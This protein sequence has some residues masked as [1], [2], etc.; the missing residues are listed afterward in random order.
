MS[1]FGSK[2]DLNQGL[3]E[4]PLV[5]DQGGFSRSRQAH[6]DEDLAFFDLKV[7][8]PQAYRCPPLHTAELP[9][10][11]GYRLDIGLRALTGHFTSS[12]KFSPSTAALR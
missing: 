2:A 5:A 7:D 11:V 1:A 3:A 6:D 12:T 10:D 9:T 8:V 4:D